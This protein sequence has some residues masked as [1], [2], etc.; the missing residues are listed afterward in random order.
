MNLIGLI[1]QGEINQSSFLAVVL[2]VFYQ[3]QIPSSVKQN[4]LSFQLLKCDHITLYNCK[5]NMIF[6]P[7]VSKKQKKLGL[8]RGHRV[9]SWNVDQFFS[10]SH[11]ISRRHG[12][13]SFF[14]ST[15]KTCPSRSLQEVSNVT[16]HLPSGISFQILL[17]LNFT[18]KS[19][20]VHFTCLLANIPQ[21]SFNDC[22]AFVLSD[23]R[24]W[25]WSCWCIS[26]VGPSTRIDKAGMQ[27]SVIVWHGVKV[28]LFLLLLLYFCKGT[29]TQKRS[30]GDIFQTG[31]LRHFTAV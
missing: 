19:M 29:E 24:T 23:H 7:L 25:E 18:I 3:P 14:K 30:C 28:S 13:K 12:D 16:I 22:C 31:C 9:I 2:F 5:F 10:L 27:D 6:R 15:I 4:I 8:D 26:R 20:C 17:P 1:T 11:Y 21:I